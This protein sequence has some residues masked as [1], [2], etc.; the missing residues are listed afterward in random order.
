ML[1][2]VEINK[3]YLK[4]S[5]GGMEA[6]SEAK[7]LFNISFRPLHQRKTRLKAAAQIIEGITRRVLYRFD[8]GRR[9]GQ[10]TLNNYL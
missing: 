3:A 8:R 2:K 9:T 5:G 1:G 10:S 6:R 7:D 4:K